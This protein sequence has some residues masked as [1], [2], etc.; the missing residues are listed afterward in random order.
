[1]RHGVKT[2]KLGRTASHR[3]SMMK[4]LATSVLRQGISP[5]QADRAVVTTVERA[6]AVRGLVDRLITYAKKGDLAARRQ[7]AK[8]VDDAEVLAALFEK[9]GPR[10]QN[11]QGGYTRV[12]KLQKHRVG[13]AA[14]L[15]MIEL[16][17]NEVAPAAVPPKKEVTKKSAPKKETA[18]K[19]TTEEEVAKKSAAEEEVTKKSTPKKEGAKKGTSV[20]GKAKAEKAEKESAPE[21]AEPAEAP[22]PETSAEG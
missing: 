6:K 1:M 16:V 4:N 22:K 9:I 5:N 15:A 21:A 18:K 2:V 10:Y 12:L 8:F 17:E 14:Q 11:R 3:R 7:A 19:S 20:K 13:D